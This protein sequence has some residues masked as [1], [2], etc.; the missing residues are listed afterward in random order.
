MKCGLHVNPC[1][2]LYFAQFMNQR[3][4]SISPTM[5][6][7]ETKWWGPKESASIASRFPLMY[8]EQQEQWMMHLNT[9]CG[10]DPSLRG[11]SSRKNL[12]TW[13]KESEGET[14]DRLHR[15]KNKGR[16]D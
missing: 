1:I 9:V 8:R 5:L 16:Q 12:M 4:S 10:V 2:L 6:R 3:K 14:L 7:Q 11:W 15:G 13:P